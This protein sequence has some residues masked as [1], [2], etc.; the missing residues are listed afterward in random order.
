MHH[1]VVVVV[2][3]VGTPEKES[4]V[5]VHRAPGR[6]P[7]RNLSLAMLEGR[8]TVGVD[9]TAQQSLAMQN[10]PAMLDYAYSRD[11]PEAGGK[12]DGRSTVWDAWLPPLMMTKKL[13]RK[14]RHHLDSTR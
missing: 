10:F 12:L 14:R 2:V 8:T 6:F 11:L 9:C 5:H 1:L 3:V 7:C 4:Q 13:A